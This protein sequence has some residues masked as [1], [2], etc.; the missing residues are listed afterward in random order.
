MLFFSLFHGENPLAKISELGELLLDSLKP[1]VSLAVSHLSLGVRMG[2][3]P[4]LG[5]QLLE[6]CDLS[7][8]I[9]D[10]FT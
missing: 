2:L 9:A 8:K 4:V 5:I 7:A 1:F 3:A 6:V 10:F